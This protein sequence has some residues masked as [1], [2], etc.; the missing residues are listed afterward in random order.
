MNLRRGFIIAGVLSGLQVLAMLPAWGESAGAQGA[1]S[2]EVSASSFDADALFWQAT[3]AYSKGEYRHAITLYEQSYA[4]SRNPEALY[5][6]AQCFRVLNDCEGA[7]A[8]FTRYVEV[9]RNLPPQAE[10]W[11]SEVDA[12]CSTQGAE[13]PGAPSAISAES[14]PAASAS[15]SATV[16]NT[17]GSPPSVPHGTPVITATPSDQANSRRMGSTQIVAWSLVG[18]GVASLAASTMFALRASSTN[19]EIERAWT[20]AQGGDE[21]WDDIGGRL[22]RDQKQ[23]ENL[24]LGFGLAGVALAGAGLTLIL[25]DYFAGSGEHAS[26][27]PRLRVAVSGSELGACWGGAF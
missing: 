12:V 6:V 13:V 24:A 4:L 21:T 23:E 2:G 7:L 9:Q 3:D 20:R 10:R 17:A 11:R 14:S 16:P 15:A 8:A 26:P 5:N 1:A 18:T 22:E 25:G 27:V 19:A